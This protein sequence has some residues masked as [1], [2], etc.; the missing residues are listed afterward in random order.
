MKTIANFILFLLVFFGSLYVVGF[1]FHCGWFY[2][3]VV[4]IGAGMGFAIAGK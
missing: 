3:S 1:L 2:G 4:G